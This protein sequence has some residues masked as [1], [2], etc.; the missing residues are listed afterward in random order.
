MGDLCFWYDTFFCF[1]GICQ[2]KRGDGKDPGMIKKIFCPMT[3]VV[4]AIGYDKWKEILGACVC[5][6]FYTAFCFNPENYVDEMLRQEVRREFFPELVRVKR[7]FP[8]VG[9]EK[10]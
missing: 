7:E 6:C 3:T 2:Q 10:V 9:Y 8:E 5:G 4:D 1:G